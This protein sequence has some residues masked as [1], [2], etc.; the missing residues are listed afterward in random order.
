MSSYLDNS[1][2]N[3]SSEEEVDL[4]EIFAILLRYKKSIIFISFI[5]LLIGGMYAY[6]QVTIYKSQLSVQILKK[7]DSDTL[8]KKA[9]GTKTNNMGNEV[10]ILR[11]RFIALK[12]LEKLNI[13]TQYFVY[14]NLKTVELYKNAP[15]VVYPESIDERLIGSKI[16]ITPLDKKT[17]NLSI[18]PSFSAK[19]KIRL[20]SFLGN[21]AKDDKPIYF[22]KTFT[23]GQKIK[24]DLFSI[25][26]INHDSTV[27]T[28]YAFSYTPKEQMYGKIQSS[29]RVGGSDKS[30]ILY[31]T[32]EDNIPWR[33]KE[34]LNAL[35]AAYVEQSIQAKTAG[36]KHTLT[37]I[38][39]QL[40]DINSALEDSGT[41]LK[42]YKSS[43]TIIDIKEKASGAATKLDDLETQI[44]ELETQQ[45]V[46]KYLLSY[47][48]THENIV[49]IDV[50]TGTKISA[51]IAD[52]IGK[53]QAA[54]SLY[55]SMQANYTELHPSVIKVKQELASLKASLKGTI[56]SSLR[57]T[58]QRKLA[59]KKIISKNKK[60]LEEFPQQEQELSELARSY[61]VNEGVYDF[62][63]KKRVETAILE[64]STDSGVRIIDKAITNGSP[65]K[66]NR[67]IIT[68]IG[69]IIGL[70]LGVVQA[71]LRNLLSNQIFSISDIEKKTSLPIYAV[72]PFFKEKKT[73]YQEALQVLLTKLEFSDKKSKVITIT[74]SVKG[75][76]RTTT[77]I[78]FAKVIAKSSRKVVV[79]D[80]DMRS[81][82]VHEKLNLSNTMGISDLLIG[83]KSLTEVTQRMQ[84]E[85]LDI[86]AS[87][88]TPPNPYGLI[89][90]EN[91]KDVMVQLE[92]KYDYIII[93]SPAA[94]LVAD[95]LVLMQLS[96]ISLIVFKAKYSKKSFLKNTNRFIQ[97]HKLENVGIIL[98]ALDL[99]KIRP[100]KKK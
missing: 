90:S 30:S 26:V 7:Q 4:K 71:F 92:E 88:P 78:E 20:R 28:V 35:I 95:A 9:L 93:E 49:G 19:M 12:T 58:D 82:N 60:L 94:G 6:F 66:P 89:M 55:D 25:R 10:A 15:F 8:M 84:E 39:K 70:V 48:K 57:G 32:Y 72:L 13:G 54:N 47:L 29:L 87:G 43:H 45:S 18:K 24:N 37:F 44:Y 17:F 65:I 99:K 50:G 61:K 75:E 62:L 22:S 27:G 97:E 86:I 3:Y 69:F 91:M 74:S 83:R 79:I 85:N 77:A 41:D 40:D 68:L 67:L 81:S 80:F 11:S 59:L 16:D 5:A 51:P 34:I 96:D 53:I 64:S 36:A 73:L 14:K 21:V 42:N 98:N 23:F 63:L 1:V 100:W 31:L 2:E 38:D 33:A 76:G 56:E 52:L 46:L